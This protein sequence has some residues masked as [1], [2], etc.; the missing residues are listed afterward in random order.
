MVDEW[1]LTSIARSKRRENL[2]GSL[3][4]L[5]L[6]AL[7][8]GTAVFEGVRLLLDP[9]RRTPFVLGLEVFLIVVGG[10][11]LWAGLHFEQPGVSRVRIT[12]GELTFWY[13]RRL[14]RPR[15][16]RW[17]SPT[18]HL[19]LRKDQDPKLNGEPYCQESSWR[20]PLTQLT[21]EVFDSIVSAARTAGLGVSEQKTWGGYR[22]W[23]RI[24]PRSSALETQDSRG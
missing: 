22:T 19:V 1:D 23:V 24:G 6:G 11:C 7:F 9:A 20:W 17:D 2:W 3:A 5:P 18:F 16:L 4:L 13:P 12:K 15:I 10:Y 21:G 14:N 8:W